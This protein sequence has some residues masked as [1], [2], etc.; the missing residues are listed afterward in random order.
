MPILLSCG[1]GKKLRVKDELAGKRVKCPD[2]AKVLLVPAAELPEP[3]E[4][5]LEVAAPARQAA[6]SR[7]G[8][9][10]LEV[11]ETPQRRARAADSPTSFW[12]N[13]GE[14]L[15]LSD[16]AL[17][18][19]SLDDE[20]MQA[21]QE[22]LARGDSAETVLGD[23]ATVI[24]FDGM[25][26]VESNLHNKSIQVWWRTSGAFSD[27]D[28][29]I[30]CADKESR[31]EI[32]KALRGRLGPNWKR[33][34]IEYSR[35]RASLEPLLIIGVFGFATFCFYMA[36][37]HPEDDK[38]GGGTKT[39]RTNFI[40]VIFVWVYNLLGPIGVVVLGGSIVALGV[41]WL[42]ARLLKP[43]IMLTLTPSPDPPRRKRRE[44]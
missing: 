38:S 2:C 7:K 14:L 34:V 37:A 35:L 20:K 6:P 9:P 28:K 21:A 3:D 16:A 19:A 22:A 41:A 13:S 23:S 24:P 40:G 32:M 26:K 4:E 43:P 18:L 15:A 27:D 29:V 42:V 33:E 1:C 12:V 30:D 17:C 31:D 36:G 44:D 11:N 5:I 8:P 39:V 10:P 25:K